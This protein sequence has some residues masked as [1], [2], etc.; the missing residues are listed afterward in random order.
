[1]DWLNPI[2][3][4]DS[5]SNTVFGGLNYSENKKTNELNYKLQ[6]DMFEYQKELQQK[7]FD[8]EDTAVQRKKAD[9]ISAGFNPLL[10]AGGSGAGAGSI[11]STITP[12]KQPNLF[13][14]G[15]GQGISRTIDEIIQ[16]QKTG[17]EIDKIKAEQSFLEQNKYKIE[18][19]TK[20]IEQNL[21][22]LKADF[23]NKN[24][25]NML[26]SV[27]YDISLEQ[28]K[29][30][31]IGNAIQQIS[32]NQKTALE[33]F[34]LKTG[35]PANLIT[36][37]MGFAALIAQ[38]V[39]DAT[40]DI[41]NA[42]NPIMQQIPLVGAIWSS[43]SDNDKI[44]ALNSILGLAGAVFGINF[45]KIK[46]KGGKAVKTQV[47]ETTTQTKQLPDGTILKQE[48]KTRN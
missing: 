19:E 48:V 18:A 43:V 27:G 34:A 33:Q 32:L 16:N 35:L 28:L 30:L 5:I 3:W 26:K 47:D 38:T 44:Q 46:M 20:N 14:D 31:T 42:V 29:G 8:R 40:S 9:L 12:Q 25:D 22:N 36:P 17:A 15:I 21:F 37:E 1:M 7:I 11:V 39:G 23:D 10:A 4:F 13:T 41:F 6:R 45:A 24:L 2:K